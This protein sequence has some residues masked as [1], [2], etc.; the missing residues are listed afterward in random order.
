MSCIHIEGQYSDLQADNVIF[1][2]IEMNTCYFHTQ[3][4]SFYSDVH[5][6]IQSLF[7]YIQ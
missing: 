3:I 5:A 1:L 6:N 2:F 4:V 7:H